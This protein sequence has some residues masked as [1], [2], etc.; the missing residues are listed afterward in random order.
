M[1]SSPP[2]AGRRPPHYCL[3]GI[4]SEIQTEIVVKATA[5]Q[6]AYCT[7][8]AGNWA[9]LGTARCGMVNTGRRDMPNRL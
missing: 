3:T 5:G 1:L 7:L 8:H 9:A 2:A 6:L 4:V